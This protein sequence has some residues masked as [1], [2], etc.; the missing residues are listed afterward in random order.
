MGTGEAE[1]AL[2]EL[3]LDAK[4]LN[5]LASDRQFELIADAMQK[6]DDGLVRIRQP[7]RALGLVFA[8][9][10]G[11]ADR[12]VCEPDCRCSSECN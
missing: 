8:R 3:Q 4:A 1:K 6:A 12:R 10:L 2:E 5:Q 9:E 11:P 7:S